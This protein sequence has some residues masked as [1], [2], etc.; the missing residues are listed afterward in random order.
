[1]AWLA[2]RTMRASC[3]KWDQDATERGALGARRSF[4]KRVPWT[5]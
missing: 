1:M 2:G 4:M 5:P 3:S